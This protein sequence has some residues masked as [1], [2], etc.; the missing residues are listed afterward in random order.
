MM[1]A[2]V[3]G[4]LGISFTVAPTVF[5]DT[6]QSCGSEYQVQTYYEFA[7]HAPDY[8]GPVDYADVLVGKDC[9]TMRADGTLRACSY[10]WYEHYDINVVNGCS[11]ISGVYWAYNWGVTTDC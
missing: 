5:A 10:R 8:S 9:Q 6:L 7:C 3:L 4:F 1:T 2:G 11:S